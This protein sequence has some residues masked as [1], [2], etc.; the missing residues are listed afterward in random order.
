MEPLPL[1]LVGWLFTLLSAA[2]LILGTMMIVALHRA[3]ELQRRFLARAAWNDMALFAIWILGLAG[4]LGVIELRPWGRHILEF[5]CWTLIALMALS[6]GTRLF[7]AT[8]QPAEERGS[9]VGAIAGVTLVAIPILVLCIATIYT[10]RGDAA[11]QA[12][13]G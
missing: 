3:G 7:A 5:F 9:W 13:G 2:A 11:R 1:A 12:F 10:L 8:R 6:A 4:G